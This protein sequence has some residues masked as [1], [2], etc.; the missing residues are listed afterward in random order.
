MKVKVWKLLCLLSIVIFMLSIAGSVHAA[1]LTTTI[2]TGGVGPIGVV[3]DP[4]MHEIFV[5]NYYSSNIQV[6]SDINNQQGADISAALTQYP[7][8]PYNFAYDSAKG[9]IWVAASTGA[10]AISDAT[11]QVV[12]NVTTNAPS[13]WGTL[14]QVAYDPGTGE[15]FVSYS[16]FTGFSTPYIQV[17]SDSTNTVLANITQAVTGIVD[18]S[19]KSE[20]F[21]SQYLDSSGS[22]SGDV[23]VISAKTNAVTNT[24][25]IGGIPGVEAYDSVKGEIFV[26]NQVYNSS[27][28][29]NYS[30]VIE[31]ISDSK[32]EV[33]ATID[34]P[35]SVSPGPMA[36][37]PN[38][39]EIYINDG[40]SVAIISDKTN[41]VVGTVNTN[42]TAA[43]GIAYDSG[44]GTVYAINNAGSDS[45]GAYGSLAV[46]SDPSSGTSTSSPT[47]APTSSSGASTSTGSTSTPKVPEF[48]S[49]ALVSVAAAIVV[50]T[51]CTVALK[52]RRR[53]TLPR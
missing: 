33:I 7:G 1:S 8:P 14:T 20:I 37:N 18:D 36:Y 27:A 34:L 10:Y 12:A 45:S 28:P 16:D 21:A 4:A 3:Y 38:K 11:N 24:I 25:P 29:N 51:L 26:A 13:G 35:T 48:S 31:V 23:Y 32:N 52:A 43:G 46:I 50:V 41:N 5:S 19:A 39:G 15:V 49:A 6:I 40:T 22:T 2:T 42:G 47:S 44:T 9:E 30:S 53:K 17:I